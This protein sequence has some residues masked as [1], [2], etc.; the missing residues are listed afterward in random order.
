MLPGVAT[1]RVATL[2][3]GGLVLNVAPC[4]RTNVL[5]RKSGSIYQQSPPM[6]CVATQRCN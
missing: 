2:D 3:N 1:V 4:Y 6:R 5:P